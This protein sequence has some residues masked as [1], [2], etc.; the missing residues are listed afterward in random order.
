MRRWSKT[1][2][3]S[4]TIDEIKINFDQD[5]MASL[6]SDFFQGQEDR[7]YYIGQTFPG[8]SGV[9]TNTKKNMTTLMMN[10]IY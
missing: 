1:P 3:G 6:R 2:H 9:Q 7:G 10:I 5:F 4:K 8:I